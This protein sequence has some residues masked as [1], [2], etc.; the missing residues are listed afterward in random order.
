MNFKGRAIYLD[1]DMLVTGDILE[2]FEHEP[3]KGKGFRCINAVRTDVSV[4]NCSYFFDKGW[5]PSIEKMRGQRA[6]SIDY[7]NLLRVHGAIDPTLPK[8][9]NDCDGEMFAT[10]P[11]E[12]R[13]LHY[14][15]VL[16]GQ[17]YRPYPN[18]RYPKAF[19]YC[20]TS[21]EAGFL[22]WD[23]YL[24]TLRAKHGEVEGQ[25]V[26]EEAKA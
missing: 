16:V 26:Y 3:A 4:I 5:W 17:P 18:V 14:T 1:A 11:N 12:V 19:P 23:T 25:R 24:E 2:L 10:H 15:N 9:W 13:L 22:W 7:I 6:R 20:E 8:T 21:R